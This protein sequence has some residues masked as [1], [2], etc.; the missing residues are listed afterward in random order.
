MEGQMT[1]YDFL[2][3]PEAP[4]KRKLKKEKPEQICGRRCDVDWCSLTCFYRRGY[5][6]DKETGKWARGI[7]GKV[8]RTQNRECDWKSDSEIDFSCFASWKN[9]ANNNGIILGNCKKEKRECKEC[10][11][12]IRFYEI[13]EADKELNGVTWGE[14][15][16]RTK[17][18][19]GIESYYLQVPK[20]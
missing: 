3:D 6:I 12:F 13:A 8:L 17:E 5:I 15:V 14:A 7:D 9:P 20:E 1:I 19:L 11:A 10:D 2:P 18:L 4:Q 16:E